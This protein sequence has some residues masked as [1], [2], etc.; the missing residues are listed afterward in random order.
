MVLYSKPAV[1]WATLLFIPIRYQTG[2]KGITMA[3]SAK[4]GVADPRLPS[5]VGHRAGTL[6]VGRSVQGLTCL[7]CRRGRSASR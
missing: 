2:S 6:P 5:D 7:S 3:R 1:Q 4:G